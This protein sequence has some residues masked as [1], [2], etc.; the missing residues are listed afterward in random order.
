MY[1][2]WLLVASELMVAI[3]GGLWGCILAA[4]K[5]VIDS[6]GWCEK[7]QIADNARAGCKVCCYVNPVSSI[8]RVAGNRDTN[9]WYVGMF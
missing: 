7:K 3:S 4:C 2:Q 6:S 9:A 8:M 5:V 1:R